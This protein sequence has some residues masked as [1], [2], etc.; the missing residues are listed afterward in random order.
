VAVGAQAASP[1]ASA[2]TSSQ[3]FPAFRIRPLKTIETA[4]FSYVK[5]GK[6]ICIEWA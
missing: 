3:C 5:P 4:V 6:I 2:V 1:P